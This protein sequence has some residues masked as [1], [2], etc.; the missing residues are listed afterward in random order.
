MT[1]QT[2][3]GRTDQ[4]ATE[5]AR[6]ERFEFGKNWADFL[7]VLDDTKISNARKSLAA[8]LGTDSLAGKRVLD[9]GSGSGLSSLVM[10]QM[11]ASALLSFDYDPNSV[12]CTRE[13]KRRYAEHDDRWRVERGSALDPD[14]LASLGTFDL[15]YSWGVL[16]HTG[17][18]WRGIELAAGRVA[19]GGQLFIAIYNDQGAWSARW[20]KIKRLYC[21]GP[22]GRGIVA[23]TYIPYQ[24]VRGLAADVVWRRNPMSRYREYGQDRGMSVVH[25]W[26]DWLGGYPFEV[27]KPE[28]IIDFGERHGFALHKLRTVGGSQGCNEFVMTRTR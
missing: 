7:R 25:D 6:G 16:H 19:A 23:A 9:I 3:D 24:V 28:E 5:V 21:S 17:E 11:G 12:A 18:M 27:A 8:M 14:Y 15:V 2:P 1:V 13:L 26:Y 10:Y 22:V 4:H 20:S